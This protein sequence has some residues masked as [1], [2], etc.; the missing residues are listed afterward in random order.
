MSFMH[1]AARTRKLLDELIKLDSD[2]SFG[3]LKV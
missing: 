3:K 2:I 1:A